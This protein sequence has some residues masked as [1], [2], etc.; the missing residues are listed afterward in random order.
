VDLLGKGKPNRGKDFKKEQGVRFETNKAIA[1]AVEKKVAEKLKALDQTK[2]KEDEIEAY[3]MSIIKKHSGKKIDVSSATA[4]DAEN[5]T[6]TPAPPSLK[7]IIRKKRRMVPPPDKTRQSRCHLQPLRGGSTV[8]LLS[9]KIKAEHG[10]L[11]ETMIPN[12]ET[13]S[14]K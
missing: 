4:D 5:P 10:T 1:S 2:N 14:L 7:G 11:M 6:T 3:I 13:N 9:R 12:G 8:Q